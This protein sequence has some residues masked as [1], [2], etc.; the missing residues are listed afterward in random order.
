MFTGFP[1]VGWPMR[2]LASTGP[3][4]VH[5]EGRRARPGKLAFPAAGPV[6]AAPVPRPGRFRCRDRLGLG[7]A[8]PRLGEHGSRD[9]ERSARWVLVDAKG[10]GAGTLTTDARGCGILIQQDGTELLQRWMDVR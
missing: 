5:R 9:P 6:R 8:Q 10:L 3:G 1:A 2:G 4:R 7:P